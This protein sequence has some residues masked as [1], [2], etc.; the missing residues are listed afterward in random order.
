MPLAQ[1]L[2]TTQCFVSLSIAAG[3]SGLSDAQPDDA[4]AITRRTKS[5]RGR[6]RCT[7]I[8]SFAA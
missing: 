1:S 5:R 3:E 7:G 6:A 2:G 4:T 8:S